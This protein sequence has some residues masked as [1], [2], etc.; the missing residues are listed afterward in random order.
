VSR[1]LG[2]LLS[3]CSSYPNCGGTTP[4]S[5]YSLV[6]VICLTPLYSLIV[7]QIAWC[8]QISLSRSLLPTFWQWDSIRYLLPEMS[9]PLKYSSKIFSLSFPLFLEWPKPVP[10]SWPSRGSNGMSANWKGQVLCRLPIRKTELLSNLY[11]LLPLVPLSF[12]TI[13]FRIF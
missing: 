1:K 8:L 6:H 13:S 7:C 11:A 5:N 3:P 10:Q 12:A 2:L 9:V 4:A